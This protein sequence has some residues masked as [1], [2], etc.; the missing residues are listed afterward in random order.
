[1]SAV[2]Q[3]IG[4]RIKEARALR[5]LSQKDLAKLV[6]LATSTIGNLEAGL[7]SQPR[8]IVAIANALNVDVNWLSTGQGGLLHVGGVVEASQSSSKSLGFTRVDHPVILDAYTVPPRKTTEELVSGTEIGPEFTFAL[9][10]EALSPDHPKGSDFIWSTTK[11]PAIGSV[12][13]L[14]DKHNL[15]HARIYGQGTGP[16]HWLAT[17]ANRAYRSF[18]SATDGIKLI[19][20][21]KYKELL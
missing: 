12:V 16:D 2:T 18:D 13:L 15:V 8:Y 14:A 10:D 20:V 6:G 7:R 17:S 19:A 9:A 21:A 11:Q 5:G 4:D 1:M 3:T